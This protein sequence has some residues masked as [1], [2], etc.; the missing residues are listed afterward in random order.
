MRIVG[1]K[2]EGPGEFQRPRDLVV[3]RDGSFVVP[4]AGH[5]AFQ[6]FG[7]DGELEHFVR[8]GARQGP[9]LGTDLAGTALRPGPNGRELYR[10][11]QAEAMGQI[12]GVIGQLLGAEEKET[13]G[14]DDRGIERLD[15]AG[16]VVALQPVLQAWRVPREADREE[17]SL[18]DLANRSRIESAVAGAMMTMYFEPELY[19]DVLLDGTIA[20]S[21]SSAYAIKLVAPTGSLVGVLQRPYKPEAVDRRIRPARSSACVMSLTVGPKKTT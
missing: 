12:F 1:R 16:D 10:Q 15:L 21:D 11:G 8:M 17:L 3:W 5:D 19:W 9:L 4:D 18:G 20:Y 13:S 14:V 6:I 2:G 7:P